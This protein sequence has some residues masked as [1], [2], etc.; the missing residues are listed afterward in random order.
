MVSIPAVRWRATVDAHF[1]FLAEFGFTKVDSDDRSFW[2][3]WVQYSSAQ[4]AVR[5]AWSTEF[6]RVDVNLIRLVGG[7]VPEYPIWV[8][9]DPVNWALLDTVL[10]ARAP[11]KLGECGGGLSDAEVEAQ[12][13]YWSSVLREIATDFLRGDCAAIDDAAVIVRAKVAANPQRVVAYLPEDAPPESALQAVEDLSST[14]PPEVEV[15]TRRYP[16]RRWVRRR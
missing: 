8:T 10:E 12:L 2:E 16:R 1:A 5:V 4:A 7:A 13:L 15:V 9:S 14:V 11:S 6:Q 3:T